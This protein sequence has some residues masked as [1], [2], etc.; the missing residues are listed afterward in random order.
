MA[1][2]GAILGLAGTIVSA[3]G[4]LAAGK[5]QAASAEYEAKQLEVRAA[6]EKAAAQREAIET[7]RNVRQLTSRQ[8]T[9]AAASGFSAMDDTVI[10]LAADTFA[11]GE[12]QAGL[13]RYGGEERAR[14]NLA[15]ADASRLTGQAAKQGAQLS[16]LGTVLGGFSSMASKYGGGGFSSTPAYRYG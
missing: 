1:G 3:A 5:A 7:R 6:E 12:Y 2:I 9:V 10:D 15:Q 14:G 4:T 13:Q 16:A 8:Q 11:R